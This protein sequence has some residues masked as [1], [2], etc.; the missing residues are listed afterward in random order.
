M[1]LA[2]LLFGNPIPKSKAE[3]EKLSKTKALPIL[4]SDALSSVA[5]ATGEILTVLIAAGAAALVFSWQI[6]I[7]IALLI[8]VVGISYKQAIDAY[9]QGGGAY[10]VARENFGPK[11]GLIAAAALMIDYVLTVAVSISAGILAVTSAFPALGNHA[12]LFSLIAILLIT[13]INLR[14]IRESAS[15]FMLPTYLFIF[16]V[17]LL[18][19]LG[20]IFML[21]GYIHEFSY[22]SHNTHAIEQ[23]SKALTLTLILR[24]FSS[25]CSAM[26][27]IE[28]VSNSVSAFKPDRAKNAAKTLM[29]LITLLIIMFIGIAY[30]ALKLKVEPLSSESVLSQLGHHIFGDGIGYYLLQASTMLVLLLAANTSFTGFPLLASIISRDGY[31]PKQLQNVGDRLAFGNGIVILAVLAAILIIH[32]DANTSAL[33]PLYAFGVFLAFTLCQAGLVRVWFERRK[34]VGFWWF[35]ALINA[36]GCVCTFIAL[37]VIIESKFLEGAWIVIV[38]MPILF[39]IFYK[40]KQHYTCVEKELSLSTDEELLRSSLAP[41]TH[42]KVIIPLSRLHKGTIAAVNFARSISDD[43]T[44]VTVNVNQEETDKLLRM[45]KL[46]NIPEELIVVKSSYQST[47]RPLIRAIHKTDK[48]DPEKGLAIIVLPNAQT[49]R[50]WQSLLHNQK[51]ALLKFALRAISR[52][53]HVGETRIIVEVPY[54]L[55]STKD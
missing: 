14:G 11:I 20:I 28:A 15:I 30:L 44:P 17:L 52:T 7:F 6:S 19:L 33:I 18:V 37:V 50:F 1:K 45:W 51:T 29:T 34:R 25:G 43:I 8:L 48:R 5:Y 24:A 16:M 13:W 41:K 26:T 12:V 31:L 23:A 9:P 39:Y 10:V 21:T 54:Q 42:P 49:N 3:E 35:R 40:I 22:H 46:L 53:E 38:A 55:H 4:A 27:G 2:R 47:I 36:F 32:Y